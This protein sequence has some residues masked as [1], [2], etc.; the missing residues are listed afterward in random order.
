MSL[1]LLGS[2]TPVGHI[3]AHM[4]SLP[5]SDAD[6]LC[7]AAPL[8]PPRMTSSPGPGSGTCTADL[9]APLRLQNHI[10]GLVTSPSL[11]L[12]N[13]LLTELGLQPTILDCSPLS[14]LPSLSTP[15]WGFFPFLG[16]TPTPHSGILQIPSSMAFG[17]NCSGRNRKKKTY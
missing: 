15:T 2:E 1:T 16:K 11:S 10:L 6:T 13:A 17:L 4:A 5:C 14:P 12:V 9:L 7:W 3:P 8:R